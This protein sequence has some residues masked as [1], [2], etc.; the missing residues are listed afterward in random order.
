MAVGLSVEVSGPAVG[1]TVGTDAAAG[2]VLGDW[3]ARPR[4]ED[5]GRCSAQDLPSAPPCDSALEPHGGAC[6]WR[7]QPS[8]VQRPGQDLHDVNKPR[9]P[10]RTGG[11]GSAGN[12][13]PA[14][15]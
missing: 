4:A 3:A 6:R 15:G 9:A 11:A 14:P 2:S 1:K 10:K 12:D 7:R 5:L 13:R 8:R